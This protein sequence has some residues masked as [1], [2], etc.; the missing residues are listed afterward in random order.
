[1]VEEGSGELR[2]LKDNNGDRVSWAYGKLYTAWDW[3]WA[4][5]RDHP[6]ADTIA[7]VS[8]ASLV[9]VPPCPAASSSSNVPFPEPTFLPNP[10][11]GLLSFKFWR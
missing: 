2:G 4:G 10:F 8:L 6:D 11:Q 1:M 3:E 9:H 5:P 7:K